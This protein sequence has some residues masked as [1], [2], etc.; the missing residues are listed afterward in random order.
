MKWL[1]TFEGFKISLQ[2]TKIV[3]RD[4]IGKYKIP[5]YG[6]VLYCIYNRM[7]IAQLEYSVFTQIPYTK[8][9]IDKYNTEIYINYLETDEEYQNNGIANLLL[10][11]LIEKAKSMNIDVITLKYDLF[12]TNP[13]WLKKQYEKVGFKILHGNKMFLALK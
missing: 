11:H 2:D 8:E 3:E 13:E 1:Y 5:S 12:V 7:E 4:K 6:K 10:N 9:F